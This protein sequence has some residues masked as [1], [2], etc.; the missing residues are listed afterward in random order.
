MLNWNKDDIEQRF[1]IRG[2]KFTDCSM[3]FTAL[4]G[5]VF[6]LFFYLILYFFRDKSEYVAMFFHGGRMNRSYIPYF[7]VF[8]GMWSVAILWV[9]TKKLQLQEAALK[10]NILPDD[11]DFVLTPMTAAKVL[12]N[13]HQVVNNPGDFILF[14]RVQRSLANLKNIGRVSDA[15]AVMSAQAE[16]DEENSESSYLAVKGFIW[17]IPVLGF[18]GTVLGLAAAVGGFGSV[19]SSGAE[20]DEIKGALSGVTGGLAVAFETTL[21]ALV[22]ALIIQLWLIGVKKR[23]EDFLQGCSDY[24]HKNIIAKIKTYAEESGNTPEV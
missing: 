6:T 16:I 11:G 1:G 17:A 2:K 14:N 15:V 7:T 21:I 10:I 20:L 22:I 4:A 23:E 8:F 13:L 5:L 3:T 24:C 12:A 19:I 9:K 18:I